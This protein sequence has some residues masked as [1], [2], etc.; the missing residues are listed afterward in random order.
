MPVEALVPL[1]DRLP[2][3][4]ITFRLFLPKVLSKV[5]Q[6]LICR[7]LLVS[8]EVHRPKNEGRWGQAAYQFYLDRS[9]DGNNG[10]PA[11]RDGVVEQF[12]SLLR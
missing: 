10:G 6:F 1:P 11:K 9:G 7:L 5:P 12:C 8:Q 4:A 2:A 3:G